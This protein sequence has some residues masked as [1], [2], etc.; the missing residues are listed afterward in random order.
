MQKVKNKIGLLIRQKV[1]I[2]TLEN[3]LEVMEKMVKDKLYDSFMK[4]LGEEIDLARYRTEIERLKERVKE[5]ENEK[6]KIRK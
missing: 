4:R 3:K 6:G 2:N 5:L 1:K